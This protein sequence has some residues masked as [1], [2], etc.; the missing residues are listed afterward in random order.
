MARTRKG[1]RGGKSIIDRLYAPF[2]RLFE[3]TGNSFET[4]GTATGKIVKK[5]INTVDKVG[6]NI[7]KKATQAVRN[8]V[9]RN[10]R[11]SRKGGNTRKS[12]R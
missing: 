8:V 5:G 2:H 7:A 1:R 10:S 4:V 6:T 9:S 12:R 3:A 11:K